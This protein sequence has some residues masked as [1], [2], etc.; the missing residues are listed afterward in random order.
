MTE[1]LYFSTLISYEILISHL[2]FLLPH[3]IPTL[4]VKPTA[5]HAVLQKSHVTLTDAIFISFGELVVQ[6][7][8]PYLLRFIKANELYVCVP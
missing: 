5:I 3:D 2:Q 4:L 6:V 8:K 7:N 1:K